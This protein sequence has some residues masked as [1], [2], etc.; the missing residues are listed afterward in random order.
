MTHRDAW[1]L[2]DE[3][4]DG[5]LAADARWAVAA[6]LD[7]CAVCRTQVATQARLRGMVRERLAAVEPPPG[8]R[9]RLSSALAA[10]VVAPR[11]DALGSRSLF[12]IRWVALLGPA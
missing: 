9:G 10:E 8:L 4:L 7:E 1:V 3:F 11:A 2:L 12:P 5:A 6:H